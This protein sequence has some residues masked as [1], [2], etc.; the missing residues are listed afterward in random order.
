MVGMFFCCRC[1]SY[2]TQLVEFF[3]SFFH[4]FAKYPVDFFVRAH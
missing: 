1:V 4:D 2:D 3:M